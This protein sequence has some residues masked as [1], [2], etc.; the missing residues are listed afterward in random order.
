MNFDS[1]QFLC[2]LKQCSDDTKAKKTIYEWYEMANLVTLQHYGCALSEQLI[3]EMKI[4][5]SE[6]MQAI[7][8]LNNQAN[9]PKSEWLFNQIC[10][11][12]QWLNQLR[13]LSAQSISE[14][15]QNWQPNQEH[16]EDCC[17]NKAELLSP[18]SF[19]EESLSPKSQFTESSLPQQQT[20]NQVLN[21]TH[22]LYNKY[23]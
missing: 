11:F 10:E 16:T 20:S 7:S 19:S 14:N 8:A 21:D 18:E 1:I 12:Y 15:W 2:E 5:F 3:T 4:R 9:C 13:G 17:E 23:D 22:T 6:V